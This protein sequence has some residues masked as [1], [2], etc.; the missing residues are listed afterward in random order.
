[1]IYD[2]PEKHAVPIAHKLTERGGPFV[3]WHP[4][5]LLEHFRAI[6][7]RDGFGDVGTANCWDL[8]YDLWAPLRVYDV[9]PFRYARAA[10]RYRRSLLD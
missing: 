5:D 4:L 3:N 6:A 9:R 1:M 2:V 8:Q 7:V 10:S